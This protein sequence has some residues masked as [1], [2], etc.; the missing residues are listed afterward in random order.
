MSDILVKISSIEG[1]STFTGYEGQI[2]CTSARH[3]ILLPVVSTGS[4]RTEG[5]SE[6]GAY[7]LTHS[8]DKASP[9][10]RLAMSAGANLGEVVIT[11]MQSSGGEYIPAQTITLGN[12]YVVEVGVDTPLGPDNLPS[13]E[14]QERFALEY[15]EIRW[16]QEHVVDGVPKGKVSAA[17]N[18]S[19]QAVV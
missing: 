6:H 5:A 8:I 16:E 9:G 12:V 4:M 7:E 11:I 19:T 10:L 13:E 14:P 17:Y 3:A 18:V 15:S 1:E 2:E